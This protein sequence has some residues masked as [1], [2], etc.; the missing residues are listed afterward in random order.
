GILTVRTGYS[1]PWQTRTIQRLGSCRLAIRI[2]GKFAR[3]FLPA[4]LKSAFFAR[5]T[6]NGF[7]RGADHE[8]FQV[9]SDAASG[10]FDGHGH[11]RRQGHVG[12]G[13]RSVS[14]RRSGD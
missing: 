5:T 4:E 12:G 10:G 6:W 13:A 7:V 2:T 8:F 9:S 3:S 1:S 11:P 14:G